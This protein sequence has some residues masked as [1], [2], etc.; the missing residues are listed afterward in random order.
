MIDF[1]IIDSHIHL[2]DRRRF[3]YSWSSGSSWATGAT[4]LNRDWTADDLASYSK[5]YNVEGFVFVEADVDIPQYR[6]EADWAT[7][8]AAA[9]RRIMACVVCLPLEQGLSIELEIARLANLEPVRGIRRL[10]QNMP[11]SAV[12]LQDDFL[13]AL[14]L[15]PKYGLSFD[16]CIDPHQF[17]HAIEMVARCPAVSF[18]LD[19][20]GK[21]DVRENQLVPWRKRIAELAALPNVVCKISGLLTQ[22]DHSNWSEAQVIPLIDHVIDCFTVDRVLFG[23]DWPVLELAAS[24][25]EWVDVF[26]HATR[27]LSQVDRRK[28]FRDNAIKSYRLNV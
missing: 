26:D 11:D 4:K 13:D 10:I 24:Y 23:G 14:K 2:L 6:V 9:D 3:D 12:I 22:A 19:H 8:S 28:I 20:M 17:E 21:P 1:P 7:S 25:R 15:L 27:H 18:I 16:I 5:P